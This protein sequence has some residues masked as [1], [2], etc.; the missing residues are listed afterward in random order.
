MIADWAKPSQPSAHAAK[1]SRLVSS[2]VGDNRGPWAIGLAAQVVDLR[3]ARD[4]GLV[5]KRMQFDLYYNIVL[6][7]ELR[8]LTLTVWRVF[9][10]RNAH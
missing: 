2:S 9:Y 5:G 10:S 1:A 4:A 3:P 8:I 6:W 7:F